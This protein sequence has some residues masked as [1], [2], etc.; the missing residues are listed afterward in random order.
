MFDWSHE[1]SFSKF[2]IA[3]NSA[4]PVDFAKFLTITKASEPMRESNSQNGSLTRA[5]TMPL[6]KL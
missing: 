1:F 4:A 6:S 2:K 5:M 3:V